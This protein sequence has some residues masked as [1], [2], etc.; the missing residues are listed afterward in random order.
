[1]AMIIGICGPSGSG[2][3][4]LANLLAKE[5]AAD[6]ISLDNYF[7]LDTPYK[8]YNE[9]GKDLELPENTDWKAVASLID[10]LKAGTKTAVRKVSWKTNSYSEVDLMP[11]NMAIIE[12]F[13]LLH[14]INIVEKLD[15]S[16]Y[17]DVPDEVGL[18]RRI[19][20]EGTTENEKWFKE[21]TF[22][23]YTKRRKIFKSRADLVLNG[24][25]TLEENLIIL[26]KA[27]STLKT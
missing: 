19:K 7:L 10:N 5:N 6:V 27:I 11:K 13:L 9:Q 14:D 25:I 12:G 18:A 4:T 22:P 17:I 21:V 2:K 16:V 1:M 26:K 24:K 15:L 8:K 20:R 3:T 23:E